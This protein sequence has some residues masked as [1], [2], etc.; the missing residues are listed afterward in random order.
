MAL[1]RLGWRGNVAVLM[2]I[3]WACESHAGG[4]FDAGNL[5]KLGLTAL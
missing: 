4:A 5:E 2:D 3:R 1:A